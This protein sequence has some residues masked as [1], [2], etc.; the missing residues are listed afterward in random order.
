L[1]KKSWDLVKMVRRSAVV[2]FGLCSVCRLGL[3]PKLV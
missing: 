3:A 2:N 1:L